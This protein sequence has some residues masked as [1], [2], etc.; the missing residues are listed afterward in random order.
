M[1]KKRIE[2]EINDIQTKYYAG[3]ENRTALNL[4]DKAKEKM[5]ASLSL[6]DRSIEALS[7]NKI[8]SP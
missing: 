6:F 2:F 3:I 7:I 5:R 1:L 8:K 4:I